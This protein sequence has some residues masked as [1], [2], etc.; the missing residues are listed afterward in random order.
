MPPAIV[1][2]LGVQAA[3]ALWAAWSTCAHGGRPLQV[4]HR[5]IKPSNLQLSDRGQLKVLDFGIASASMPTREAHTGPLV[6]GTLQFMSPERQV[7]ED[8]HAGD[9][10]ALGATLVELLRGQPW[11][12][13]PGAP[14]AHEERVDSLL[15][16]VPGLPQP[17]Y[18][19]LRS[20]LAYYPEQRPTARVAERALFDY[21]R[22]TP[23]PT[24]RDWCEEVV[25]PL[26]H[27]REVDTTGA[28]TSY[29]ERDTSVSG[30]IDPTP[31][32]SRPQEEGRDPA[33]ARAPAPPLPAPRLPHRPYVD[34]QE[35]APPRTHG[36][37]PP[38]P[39]HPPARSAEP[40]ALPASRRPPSER[41]APPAAREELPPEDA[42]AEDPGPETPAAAPDSDAP[43]GPDPQAD[44]ALQPLGTRIVQTLW[45][46]FEDPLMRYF[47]LFCLVVAVL[48]T[49]LIWSAEARKSRGESWGST[50]QSHERS[51]SPDDAASLAQ[52]PGSP[53][54]P[55]PGGEQ[56]PGS[57]AAPSPESTPPAAATLQPTPTSPTP[58]SSASQPAP[59]PRPSAAPRPK[60]APEVQKATVVVLGKSM[61]LVARAPDGAEYKVPGEL[62]PGDY[63]VWG[64]FRT[65]PGLALGLHVTPG[66]YIELRC[67]GHMA[68]CTRADNA[69]VP[70]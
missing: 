21:R 18:D 8:S 51:A 39:R 69:Q 46:A 55:T 7:G 68:R 14:T 33:P 19:T 13:M 35:T 49:L 37:P 48:S 23:Y 64:E 25:V 16:S 30:D 28:G 58:T 57:P 59:A 67:D 34:E 56:A 10:Y 4:L 27:S 63:A 17:M 66:E 65:G 47:A 43:P 31:E 20:M 1:A 11:L 44:P 41:A 62:P 26:R 32:A 6:L 2:D 15:R 22:A 50:A 38:E 60:P 53:Q 45:A 3:D 36:E 42:I 54:A 61:R 52:A 12:R 40:P 29:L 5:D 24:L 9:V 70:P